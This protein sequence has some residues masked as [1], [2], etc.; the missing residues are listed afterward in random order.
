MDVRFP[1]FGQARP[2][3]GPVRGTPA[4]RPTLARVLLPV[5]WMA[6]LYGLLAVAVARTMGVRLEPVAI[7]LDLGLHLAFAAFV[8]LLARR[9]WLA[10]VIV[11]VVATVVTVGNALKIMILGAPIVPD[12]LD[13]AYALAMIAPR[14]LGIAMAAGLFA[15][16]ALLL[17][18]LTLRPRAAWIAVAAVAGVFGLSAAAPGPVV[19]SLDQV[20]GHSEWNQRENYERRGPLLYLAMESARDAARSKAPPAAGAVADAAAGLSRNLAVPAV[21]YGPPPADAWRLD[22]ASRAGDRSGLADDALALMFA[23]FD[24]APALVATPR[25]NLH[26]I[27]LESF[28][29]P[30]A[31]VEAGIAEDPFDPRFRAL[32]EAAGRSRALSP[33]FGGQTANAEF[34]AL[35]GFPVVRQG[36]FFES[37]LRNAAPCLPRHLAERGYTTI[38]S[39]P[40]VAAFWNRTNA[41]RRVGFE[42][43]LSGG[44]FVRDDMVRDFLS[45]SSLYAQVDERIRP[46]LAAGTPLFNYVLTIYGHLDYPVDERR[47]EVVPMRT[48][49]ELVRRFVSTVH[50]KT[51]ELMDHLDDL[52]QRD[53]DAVI[54]VFGDH[55]PYL[56][57][58][59]ARSGV[60]A[61]HPTD[62]TAA[63]VLDRSATPLLV[64]DGR[65]GPV[66]VGDL[67]I[68]RIP[69]LVLDLLGDETPSVMDLSAPP[70]GRTVRP[71]PGRAVVAGAGAPELCPADAERASADCAAAT[72]WVHDVELIATDLFSG[73]QHVMGLAPALLPAPRPVR[74]LWARL[75]TAPAE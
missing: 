50:Y 60:L 35:C 26:M 58:A 33:V 29:D 13:G 23:E 68:F 30:T 64:I 21:L 4:R 52:R 8:G 47:P 43:Y 48:D 39:H 67:P 44:D 11:T 2:P 73:R 3:A 6:A 34:E 45:D 61:P 22:A 71:L 24:E 54:V 15:V 51:V 59:Y 69:S 66:V 18:S 7:L 19:A 28:W 63:M 72:A 65:A 17:A 41:Y 62:N 57:A 14:P 55:L 56:G 36:V 46:M 16:C 12:D 1:R 49:D 37:G 40:N 31:L 70:E 32:W 38:A 20:F 27:V 10:I 74:P 75:T 25:R 5:A 53:P 42:T 9:T